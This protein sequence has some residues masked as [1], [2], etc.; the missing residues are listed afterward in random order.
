MKNIIRRAF[1]LSLL[2]GVAAPLPVAAQDDEPYA[3]SRLPGAGVNYETRLSNVEDQMR[4]LTGKVEQME[5]SMRRL[6]NTLQ[7]MQADYDQR[8]THLENTPN[9]TTIVQAA[10]PQA[11]APLPQATEEG[12]EPADPETS[13]RGTLGALKVQ[14]DKVTGAVKNPKA[15]PLPEAPADYGLTAQEQYDRAFSLL[16]QANYDDAEKSFKVFIDK[17][18]NDKLIDNAKYWYAETFYVRTKFSDA[19]V[20]F[21]DA[22]QQNPKGTKAPDSLLKLGLSLGALDK[23]QDA[24]TTLASLK[25]DYPNAAATI[26]ARANQEI[27]RL[28][29]GAGAG[30]AKKP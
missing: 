18:P 15:P 12:S 25:K 30:P 9:T 6:E 22:F 7:R 21:A 11:A 4:A 16:R 5:F 1:L 24:C 10:P 26:R 17:Y 29:C 28:K 23:A 14:N 27:A 8:I 13:V 3:P 19:A 20:A 2:I